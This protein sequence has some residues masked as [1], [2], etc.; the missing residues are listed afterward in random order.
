MATASRTVD[1]LCA[2]HGIDAQQLAVRSGVEEQRVV[3]I[4]LGRWTPSPQD[5]DAI[6]AS[7][8]LTRDQIIWGHRIPVQHLYGQGPA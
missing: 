6:A 7:F 8:G 2:E 4:L 1:Q 5:R 3:A